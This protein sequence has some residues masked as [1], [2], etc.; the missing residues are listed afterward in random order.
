MSLIPRYTMY[1][2]EPS[3]AGEGYATVVKDGGA[4]IHV[5]GVRRAV[6][7]QLGAE[8]HSQAVAWLDG[9]YPDWRNPLAYWE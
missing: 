9:H 7:Y 2:Y 3:D 4:A 8:H 5:V 6:D 1:G